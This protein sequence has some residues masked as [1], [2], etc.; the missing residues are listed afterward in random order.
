MNRLDTF[1]NWPKP[2][3]TMWQITWMFSSSHSY[4]LLSLCSS[5]LC[6][7]E[8][9]VC[10]TGFAYFNNVHIHNWSVIIWHMAKR[11]MP[12]RYTVY[13]IQVNTNN[14]HLFIKAHQIQVLT[15]TSSELRI[16]L[17]FHTEHCI[18]NALIT[19]QPRQASTIDA[20][21]YFFVV[22]LF[23]VPISLHKLKQTSGYNVYS[24]HSNINGFWWC[25]QKSIQNK[26]SHSK[27]TNESLFAYTVKPL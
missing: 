20:I 13:S 10:L 6:H 14:K 5:Q 19:R 3:T 2:I 17:I 24:G 23:F 11:Q 7:R 15:E 26:A 18:S 9:R 16:I 1:S 22:F 25:K 27:S 8:N 4:R 21:P 12:Y